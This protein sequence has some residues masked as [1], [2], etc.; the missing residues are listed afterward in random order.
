DLGNTRGIVVES[1]D[2]LIG[3][4]IAAARNVISGN[5]SDGITIMGSAIPDNPVQGNFIGT[6]RFGTG[7]L[8]NQGD[9]IRILLNDNSSV[10][11]GGAILGARNLSSSNAGN[12]ISI[13][14]GSAAVKGNFIGADSAGV[15]LGNARSGIEIIS[16]SHVIGGAISGEGNIITSNGGM[17]PG[18]S[19]A[20][21][22]VLSSGNTILSNSIF[23]NSGLGI[24]LVGSQGVTPND[25]CDTDSGPNRL[26]NFPEL[27]S[28]TTNPATGTT[29]I[30]GS[31]NSA[32]GTTFTIQ[33]FSNLSCD[34]SGN[35]EGETFIGSTTV[36]ATG[37]CKTFFNATL[38]NLIPIGSFITATAT[39]ALGNTSE[40]SRCILVTCLTGCAPSAPLFAVAGTPISF[41]GA[42]SFNCPSSPAFDWSFG[43]GSP[44]SN[45]Q[46][47]S[48]TYTAPGVYTW[49]L[50]VSIG[51]SPVCTRTGTISVTSAGPVIDGFSPA[52]G[53]AGTQVIISGQ[54]FTGASAVGFNGATASFTVISSSQIAATVPVGAT[55]GPISVQTPA[56]TAVSANDFVVSRVS[57]TVNSA[58][59]SNIRDNQL[60]L[61]EAILIA[62]GA[63][64]KASLTPA[65]QAL[66]IG[67]P[68]GPSLDTIGFSIGSGAQSI[69][70]GSGSLGPLPIITGPVIIDATT[71]PGF[72]GSPLIELNGSSAGPSAVGLRIS[73]GRSTVRGLVI[74]RFA[75]DAIILETGGAN[76]VEG[77]FIGTS[78]N[79]SAD[80]GNGGH[81]VS[82]LNSNNNVIGGLTAPARNVISGNGLRGVSIIGSRNRVQGNY[83]GTAASALSPSPLLFPATGRQSA[84]ILTSSPLPL[85]LPVVAQETVRSTSSSKPTSEPLDQA[86]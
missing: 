23:S 81:G 55:T 57:I 76:L 8:G 20:G 68:S 27:I 60:T 34:S 70:V 72:A 11:I 33:F 62:N 71:Q 12:G 54:G 41:T 31:L 53:M 74:N 69:D 59:D 28:V 30:Q 52:G 38:S 78:L 19:S 16:G 5:D 35:G 43:D 36:T 29:S 73:A 39:D 40:F 22:R 86:H 17:A 50:T 49:S 47:P 42:V 65:E 61:R 79:G 84:T 26:Q 48:H 37:S 9:G 7:A 44:N 3:G 82:I 77:N 83:I 46:N 4:T 2:N 6:D 1:E 85:L 24:D 25:P 15:A 58:A 13:T 66:V 80:Q 10:T 45:L 75:R 21:V 67:A 18:F 51:N 14:G 32:P 56:G 64:A 63:L